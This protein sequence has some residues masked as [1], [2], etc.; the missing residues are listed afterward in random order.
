MDDFRS[1]RY[2]AY[3]RVF[4]WIFLISLLIMAVT[5]YYKD[6][7][8]E[9]SSYDMN[10]LGDPIQTPTDREPFSI[11]ANK[12]HYSLTPKFDYDLTG[13]VVT[14]NDASGLADIW[15]YDIWKDFINVRDL[16]V[17]WGENVNSG[18]YKN[19][20]FT[21]DS[22]T[23]WAA[24]QDSNI[25]NV[26]KG[27]A[28]S[29]NHLLTDNQ[30]VKQRLLQAEKG[31]VVHFKGVLTDYQNDDNGAT[32]GTS[33]TRTDTG[34]GAC[35]TVYIDEF[36]IVKKANPIWHN[37]YFL[38]KWMAILSLIGYLIMFSITPFKP[39]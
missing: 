13:V 21:S 3:Q 16:C 6:I 38:S 32:R 36:N 31:D 26:F 14:Y 34:N 5:Y 18:I 9:P 1:T 10:I 28:L 22:W 4:K 15:H 8:P 17:I 25:T 23:C 35:E 39:R 37:F 33:T 29:N 20:S 12:Q 27:T 19:I 30:R 11:T 2:V 24:W 7:F